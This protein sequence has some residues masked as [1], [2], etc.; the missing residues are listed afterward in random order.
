MWWLALGVALALPPG[1]AH[2]GPDGLGWVGTL[3][4]GADEAGR[5]V[6]VRPSDGALFLEETDVGGHTFSYEAGAFF[7]NG[8]PLPEALPAPL[9]RAQRGALLAGLDVDGGGSRRFSYDE[10]GRLDGVEWPDGS[11]LI[12]R[13]DRD[14]RVV[15]LIGPGPRQIELRYGEGLVVSSAAQGELSIRPTAPGNQGARAVEVRD[16]AGR[17]TRTDYGRDGRGIEVIVGWEDPRGRQ[18]SVRRREGLVEVEADGRRF[19]VEVDPAGRPMALSLPGGARWRWERDNRGRLARTLDGAGRVHRIERD[20]QGRVTL[21]SVGSRPWA[22]P[23]DEAGQITGVVDPAGATTRL[24]FDAA[25]RLLSITD[26]TGNLIRLVRDSAGRLAA[27]VERDGGKLQ[28][29]RDL[30]GRLT[31]AR[32]AA[33]REVELRWDAGGRLV[34]I[35]D[36][37]G[38]VTRWSRGASGAVTRIVD[39]QGRSTGL[40]RD[41]AG[42]L[43]AIARADGSRLRLER[44]V[45]GELS[46]ITLGAARFE[47][48][49]DAQGQPLQAGPSAW[50][51]DASGALIEARAPG[52][53]LGMVRDGAG[54][55]SELV[56]PAGWGIRV[57]RDLSARL[58]RVEG[59]D[60]EVRIERDPVGRT[61]REEVRTGGLIH[62]SRLRYDGRGLRVEAETP[63]GARRWM[64]DAAGRIIRVVGE[65][66]AAIGIDR[67]AAGV[68][69]LLRLPDGALLRWSGVGGQLDEELIGRDGQRL[70]SRRL[71]LAVD[72][73]LERIEEGSV[74][75]RARGALGERVAVE[76]G[77]AT[78]SVAPDLLQG[79]GLEVTLDRSGRWGE[80]RVEGGLG[81]WTLGPGALA[82]VRD[83]EGRLDG[84]IGA[85]GFVRIE[86]DGR[87]RMSGVGGGLGAARITWDAL[88]R[89]AGLTGADGQWMPIVWAP[90][91][92]ADAGSFLCLGGPTPRAILWAPWGPVSI[93]GS[94]L[95]PELDGT[96]RLVLDGEGG[97]LD[98]RTTP[99][100]LPDSA[101]AGFIGAQ[102]R[103]QLFAGGPLWGRGGWEDPVSGGPVDGGARLL[104]EGPERGAVELLDPAPYAPQAV[105]ADP[106]GI[107]TALGALSPV[108]EGPWTPPLW[109]V[110]DPLI[111]LPRTLSAGRRQ[112]GPG[113][114]QLPLR[115]EPVVAALLGR[116]L[117]GQGP[118]DLR[119]VVEA[120][121]PA[122]VDRMGIPMG[123]E[124]PGFT[125][126]RSLPTSQETHIWGRN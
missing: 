20:P 98:L 51:W 86:R 71:S 43:T 57:E 31:A 110:E 82:A 16:G 18:T 106:I 85:L 53:V 2:L 96:P 107:L 64:Y 90:D 77:E 6:V 119:A 83:A 5:S 92:Q 111:G 37:T 21:S 61:L 54:W 22:F 78:F 117:Q 105:W 104:G 89:P 34:Q 29:K 126:I 7:L 123:A 35:T 67:D 59:V 28:I 24:G 65:D 74:T 114:G 101:A 11:R 81:A 113:E 32:D 49:R 121:A 48:R 42:R 125:S 88:G 87:G 97:A 79:L 70:G 26:P 15:A 17:R 68:P 30:L 56:S 10:A 102:G 63:C 115:L 39:G 13:Y 94:G 60:G 58:R 100:G 23:R 12:V 73:G 108:D 46:A 44:D 62:S 75:S 80:A 45:L 9:R 33:G 69:T 52:V 36:W 122:V 116:V 72:G 93:A 14:S 3:P 40:V 124:P 103:L 47:L 8:A 19:V 84:V 1:L 50:R 99:T 76:A 25:G 95:V 120:E 55:L 66:G 118:L 41:A 112:P 109:R 91:D 27:I 38:V 4:P